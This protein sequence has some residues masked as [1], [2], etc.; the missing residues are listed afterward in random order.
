MRRSIAGV[1]TL[2]FVW[3]AGFAAAGV[4]AGTFTIGWG[5]QVDDPPQLQISR[6]VEEYLTSSDSSVRER[7]TTLWCEADQ[8]RRHQFDLTDP[9][10]YKGVGATLLEVT[11][12]SKDS[13]EYWV[14]TLFAA[15]GRDGIQ[16]F[17]VQRL[18]ARRENGRWVLC[19]ALDRMTRGWNR[20]V[21]GDIEYNYPDEWSFDRHKAESAAAFVERIAGDFGVGEV[22]RIGYFLAPTPEALAETIGLDWTIPGVRGKTYASD[23]L[24][25]VGDREQ[26]EAYLHELVHIV[27][28]PLEP[29]EGWHPLISEGIA[30]WLGG[31]RGLELAELID[32]LLGYQAA[33]PEVGFREIVDKTRHR[34]EVGYNTGAL[35]MECLSRKGGMSSVQRALETVDSREAVYS[36]L[37]SELGVG[38]SEATGWWRRATQE[39][40]SESK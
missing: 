27:L 19:G 35:I 15:T 40:A 7:G 37:A 4:P 11:P 13:T 2:L 32:E 20:R 14:K 28:S 24:I 3:W 33:H 29:A 6:V 30:S 23:H 5:V 22:P 21:V 38:E 16:P 31:S 39:I 1:S 18:L 9:W 17:G 10:V 26:G 8:S 25:F 12:T 36:L 34:S